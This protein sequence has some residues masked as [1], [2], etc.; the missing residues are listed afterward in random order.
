MDVDEIQS[1]DKESAI[2]CGIE[3]EEEKG[4][5]TELVVGGGLNGA[6]QCHKLPDSEDHVSSP[7]SN[8]T[9]SQ[10]GLQRRMIFHSIITSCMW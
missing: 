8:E 7:K 10:P 1:G 2:G 4:E 9:T 6:G 3:G 5:K